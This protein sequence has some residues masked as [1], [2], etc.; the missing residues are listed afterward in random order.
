MHLNTIAGKLAICAISSDSSRLTPKTALGIYVGTTGGALSDPSARLDE[1]V[2]S[3]EY[4]ADPLTVRFAESPVLERSRLGFLP[5]I[6][7]RHRRRLFG[8]WSLSST[9]L[10]TVG[11]ER[12]I[13]GA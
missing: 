10:V 1:R 6:V 2:S 9:K 13:H 8:W 12:A 7:R 4:D 5:A 3:P 11:D